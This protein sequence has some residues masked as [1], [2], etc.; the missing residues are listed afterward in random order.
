MSRDDLGEGMV[1]GNDLIKKYPERASLPAATI[2]KAADVSFSR[3][4]SHCG[5]QKGHRL[6][7]VIIDT[8]GGRARIG[9]D[10]TF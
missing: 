4:P 7:V 10:G 5:A 2:Y 9:S 8:S 3:C 1:T 6:V